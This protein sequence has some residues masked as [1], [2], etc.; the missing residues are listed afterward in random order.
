MALAYWLRHRQADV[1]GLTWAAL[2]AGAVETGKTRRTLPVD[3]GAD[4]ELAS[5]I[6][7]ERARQI[8]SGTPSTHVVVCEATKRPWDRHSFG[9]AFRRIARAAGIA[10]ELQFRDL[11][12]TAL[13]ELSDAGVDVIPRSTHSGHQTTQMARRYSR[14]TT[15]QFRLA[16]GQRR[17]HLAAEN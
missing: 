16:A 13:T 17:E 6:V 5:E 9:H 14:R 3:V 12:A 10:D 1:L 4:P 11:R 15:E 2:D 7:A 8:L